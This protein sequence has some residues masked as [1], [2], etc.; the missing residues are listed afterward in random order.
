MKKILTTLI[1]TATAISANAGLAKPKIECNG[2]QANVV[3]TSKSQRLS[4]A[5]VSKIVFDCFKISNR[6]LY[7]QIQANKSI[8]FEGNTA[9]STDPRCG[10]TVEP[11]QIITLKSWGNERPAYAIDGKTATIESDSTVLV[12]E[13]I[14]CES[15]GTGMYAGIT[16]GTV[17]Q[18]EIHESFTFKN[19]NEKSGTQITKIVLKKVLD[20]LIK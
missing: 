15:I 11:L 14:S 12:R 4:T 18:L 13:P 7:S 16:N 9:D 3:I 19:E 2:A 17:A 20:D 6:V 10:Q 8:S 1:L 5:D